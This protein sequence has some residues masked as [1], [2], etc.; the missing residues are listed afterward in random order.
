MSVPF[1]TPVGRNIDDLLV[2]VVVAVAAGHLLYVITGRNRT[3]PVILLITAALAA[4]FFIPGKGKVEIG[5]L[6]AG[7][8]SSIR[9]RLRR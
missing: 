3:A 8:A 9:D 1:H 7:R 2:K 4:H 5:W 6:G